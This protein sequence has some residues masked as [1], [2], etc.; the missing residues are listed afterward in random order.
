M[1]P[2]ILQLAALVLLLIIGGAEWCPA[3]Q[4]R[5]VT[6]DSPPFNFRADNGGV[7]GSAAEIVRHVLDEAE[8]TYSMQMLPWARAYAV[9][10]RAP[11]VLIFSMARTPDRERAFHWI[12]PVAQLRPA[13]YR[14]AERTDLKAGSLQDLRGH[15]IGGVN[16]DFGL[17]YLRE[18]G[19]FVEG[20]ANDEQTLNKLVRG[21]VD[22]MLADE[23]GFEFRLER[24]G[25]ER[26]RFVK[27]LKFRA[28]S[29]DL[30][31]AA[32]LETDMTLLQRIAEA[33]DRV[34]KTKWFRQRFRGE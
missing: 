23:T 3:A 10:Q 31:L 32:S 7:E 15:V 14:L 5:V 18:N 28:I 17:E 11:N 24:L 20:V 8:V 1:R 19:F 12:G 34:A 22:Y 29:K 6:E 30:Y 2:G 16:L 27:A 21:R 26:K 25:L 13:F 33:Y 9:A 4:L